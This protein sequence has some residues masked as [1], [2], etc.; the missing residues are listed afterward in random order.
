[1]HTIRGEPIVAITRTKYVDDCLICFEPHALERNCPSERTIVSKQ[2]K[3]LYKNK[4]VPAYKFLLPRFANFVREI[5]YD[6]NTLYNILM[7]KHSTVRANHLVC[8]TLD[9][10]SLI[11]QLYANHLLTDKNI[12]TMNTIVLQQHKKNKKK[13]FSRLLYKL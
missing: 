6:G 12:V 1:V 10:Q 8:E 5:P 11:G 4:M 9:P 2:H 13:L 7:K 3:I